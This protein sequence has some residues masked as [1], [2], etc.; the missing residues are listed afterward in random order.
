[1]C[2]NLLAA[3]ELR[4]LERSVV[5]DFVEAVRAGNAELCVQAIKALET[6]MQFPAAMRAIAKSPCTSDDFRQRLL[7]I[8]VSYGDH[9]RQEVGNDLV[10]A[11]GLR[12]MLPPYTG[13]A[14][15]LYRGESAHNRQRQTYGLSWSATAEVARAFASTGM[16]RTSAGGSVL[17]ETL[18]PPEAIISAPVMHNDRYDEQEYLVDRRRLR[19]V[20]VL[21]RYRQL[22]HDEYRHREMHDHPC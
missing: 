3:A 5:R 19:A 14:I 2:Q 11:D 16:Y 17:L 12:A 18:A 4:R 20:R 9:L 10:L 6:H 7:A 21:E 8:W 15:T 1:M 22:T 13:R